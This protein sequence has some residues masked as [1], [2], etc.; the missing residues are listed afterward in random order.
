METNRKFSFFTFVSF[1]L[2]KLGNRRQIYLYLFSIFHI[3]YSH[4]YVNY[5]S[6]VASS[7]GFIFLWQIQRS[8]L[9]CIEYTCIIISNYRIPRIIY[10]IL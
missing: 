8:K 7:V 9:A 10:F 1:L 3:F 4:G 5:D 6:I 2:G